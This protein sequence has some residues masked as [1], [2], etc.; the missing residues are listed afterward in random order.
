[1]NE[2]RDNQQY[3]FT[4]ETTRRLCLLADNLA[5]C[6]CVP[7][8][9]LHTKAILLDIDTRFKELT[10]FVF[11][12]LCR[13]LHSR[14]R[15][16]TNYLKNLEYRF[17]TVLCDPPFSFVTPHI[18]AKNI[19]ALLDWSGESVAYVCYPCSGFD[20]LLAA[21]ESFGF[22]GSDSGVALEYNDAPRGMGKGEPKEIRL[23]RFERKMV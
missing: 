6:L 16:N 23:Y 17:K 15:K 7:S 10:R 18:I 21:F 22:A 14:H 2:N 1:M 11:Y 19:D 8:V 9:A 5:A 12:D 3:F 20:A 13:G 4:D